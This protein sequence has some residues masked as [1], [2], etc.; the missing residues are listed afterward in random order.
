MKRYSW[1]VLALLTGC[2][3]LTRDCSGC[4]AEAFGSDWVVITNGMDGRIVNC[5]QLHDTAID[6]EKGTDGIWWRDATSEHLVHISGW[7]SRVQVAG[8]NYKTAAAQLG[9]EPNR[10][11]GGRY[12]AADDGGDE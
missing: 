9:V 6:N 10:C 3:G 12:L 8:G 11:P 1:F 5:W 2:A 7:Y 4:S